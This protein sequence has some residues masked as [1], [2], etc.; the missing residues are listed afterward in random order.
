[1]I[2][3]IFSRR[4]LRDGLRPP[5]GEVKFYSHPEVRAKRASKDRED[6]A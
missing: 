2:E 1:M 5:Q 3:A 6:M 4:T